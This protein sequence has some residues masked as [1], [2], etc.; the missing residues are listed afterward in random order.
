M[1]KGNNKE[2]FR[3][4]AFGKMRNLRLLK[5]N[6]VHLIGSNFEHIISKELRWICWHGFP[7]KSIP[8]SFY[9]GNLVAID[10]RYSSL[11]HPWTW[12]D[13]QVN[14]YNYLIITILLLYIHIYINDYSSI[15]GKITFLVRLGL[16]FP[17]CFFNFKM[18]YL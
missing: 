2:K 3:L 18:L 5:L 7:L 13:S 8:S 15:F 17:L 4:E 1:G 14:L 11:I 10:M 9:Q 6:Y 16:N 12:R